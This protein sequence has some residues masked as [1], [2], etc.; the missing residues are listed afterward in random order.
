[1]RLVPTLYAERLE[2]YIRYRLEVPYRDVGLPLQEEFNHALDQATVLALRQSADILLRS[3]ETPAFLEEARRRGSVLYRTLVP[4]RLREQLKVL[5]GPL[6]ISTSLYG[7]PW[8]LLY[9]DEFRGLR[10]AIGKRIMISRPLAKTAGGPLRSRPRALVVGSDP[11]ATFRS[12][13][14]RSSAS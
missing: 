7:L 4:P 3:E 9:D 10:Y 12:S 2:G 11:A 5:S 1:M 13:T 14:A 6:L 8:E